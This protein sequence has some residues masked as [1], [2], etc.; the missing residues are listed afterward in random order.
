MSKLKKLKIYP[1]GESG[2]AFEAMVNPSTINYST[3]IKY[4]E[5]EAQGN[6]KS[7]NKFD[8]YEDETIEFT[9]ILDGT[10][11][12]G[13][14][15]KSVSDSI[16]KFKDIA[17]DYNGDDHEPNQVT[18]SWGETV[19]FDG[20]LKSF[21]IEY[22]LFTPEG[23]PLRADMAVSFVGATSPKKEAT[24]KSNSSPDLTHIR[25]V[26]AGDTL[27]M[28]CQ[29]IYKNSAMYIEVARVNGLVNFRQLEPGTE[30]IFP[31]LKK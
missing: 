24:I 12:V 23:N 9:L 30:I 3:E 2:N 20:R 11:I 7:E 16:Q 31:P 1:E 29:N 25:V 27:P 19:N 10:G 4:V 17:F 26:R 8:G 21:S 14:N 13:K 18:V 22:K 15:S 5:D 6:F 28:M